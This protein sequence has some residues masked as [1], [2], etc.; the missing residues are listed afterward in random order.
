MFHNLSSFYKLFFY[1]IEFIRILT[2][3]YCSNKFLPLNILREN[4]INFPHET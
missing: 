1:F 2:K 3:F 4:I